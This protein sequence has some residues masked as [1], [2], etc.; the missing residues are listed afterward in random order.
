MKKCFPM[1]LR[2]SQATKSGGLGQRHQ[3]CLYGALGILCLLAYTSPARSQQYTFTTL[4]GP[5]GGPGAIDG[6]LAAARFDVPLH[7]AVDAAGNKYVADFNNN[8]I[9][10]ITPGGMVQTLAGLAGTTGSANGTGSAA[11]FNGPRGLAVDGAGNVFV[12]DTENHTIRKITPGGL[13]TTLAGSAAQSGSANG[14]GSAARF[15]TPNGLAV[16]SATN[17]YV[18]D[19][20][21]STIRKITPAAVVTTLAGAAGQ[22]GSADGTGSS[23]RFNYPTGVAVDGAGNVYVADESNQAIRKIAPGGVVTTLAG[24]PTILDPYGNPAGGYSD[25]TGSAARFYFPLDL[26]VDS[27][28]NV[29]VADDWNQAIRKVTSAGVVTTLAGDPT[30]LDSN[31]YAVGGYSDGTGSAARFNGP[32]SVAVD[33]SGQVYVAD[34][35]N[36]VIR[37]VTAAGVVT[38]LAG[39][40][41][42]PSGTND[43]TGNAARFNYPT[44]IAADTNGILYV[45]DAFNHTIRKITSGGVVTTLAGLAGIPGSDDGTGSA[46][47]FNYPTYV[48]PDGAGNL[49]VADGHN[50][51]IRKV[52]L[53]GVVTTFVGSPGTSGSDDGV[54]SAARFNQPRGLALDNAGNLFVVD[55][56]NC[57][58]RKV[59]PAGLVTTLA[60]TAGVVG[61]ANG[62]G[63]AA[64]F[65]YPRGMTIAGAGNLYVADSIN[66][67]IRK[68][69]PAG[70]VTTLAGLAGTSGI[71]D[72]TGSAA[73]F[74][75]PFGIGADTSGNLYVGD[76][77]N[78]TIRK[79]TLAGTV[80]TLAGNLLAGSADG[81]GAA[82]RFYQPGGTAVDSA[83]NIY[84][85][86]SLNNSIRVG[87][88]NNCPDRPTIDVASGPATQMRQ[89]ET[90]PQ[91]AVAWQW[92]VIRR[93]ANSLATLSDARIRNPT[94]KP[95]VADLYIFQLQATDASGAIC[96]RTVSLTATVPPRPSISAASWGP[97]AG[98]F[99]FTIHSLAG[100]LVE[101]QTSTNLADWISLGIL[102][103]G[104]TGTAPYTDPAADPPPRFY[105]LRQL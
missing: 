68:V 6:P 60:G 97:L 50:H 30:I 10:K 34:T 42:P 83:G 58:I 103:M 44:S 24:N 51:T 69:T 3:P 36:N 77:D 27:A 47:R 40:P 74:S 85:A 52:T 90:S 48:V 56:D 31:S 45:P 75:T 46:A 32:A 76:T 59:T 61:S 66:E 26:T 104:P 11:R 84:L 82:A 35:Y 72:G 41:W 102:N 94:F 23:A 78:N 29:Y 12:A 91:T 1:S 70:V 54:G 20:G 22:T 9:R 63:S 64:Q 79:V 25:G 37:A 88:T 21:N 2:G 5:S 81:E 43:G 13:V 38:T 62:T 33:S 19:W 7:V 8:T 4:A 86:D 67:T 65:N 101:I 16:D 28:G 100:N 55:R 80:T 105:R 87:T 15:T 53:G 99:S 71:A 95:D 18:A 39:S 92:S 98:Q 49:Y 73:R 14:T 89:L 17:L 96:L 57:T 93:P